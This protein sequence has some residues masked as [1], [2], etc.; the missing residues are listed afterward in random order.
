MGRWKMSMKW[1]G[2]TIIE[3][4]VNRALSACRNAVIISGYNSGKL[5]DI[6]SGSMW[7]GLEDRIQIV[8]ADAWEEGMFAS[9][10]RG[11][12]EISDSARWCFL[13][14]ADMPLVSPDIYRNLAGHADT[15]GAW[16]SVI[17]QYK[18][19]KG[20]PVLLEK[21]ALK[22]ALTLQDNRSMRDVI[23]AFPSLIIPSNESGILHDIDTPEDYEA[24][25]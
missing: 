7:R 11:F 10:R 13:T 18:G 2:L 6:F 12:R 19:K 16:K 1:E 3:T 20:H 15:S 24:C 25:K 22:Y 5:H 9:A 4:S 8:H 23:S 14:L 17:P 21:E